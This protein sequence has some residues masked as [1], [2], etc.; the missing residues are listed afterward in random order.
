MNLQIIGTRKCRET[1]KA[2]RFFSDR[3]IHYAFVDLAERPLSAGELRNIARVLG[4]SA[5]L[6]TGSREYRRRG[7]QYMVFDT[8]SELERH[9]ELIR[10]PIVRSGKEATVG[11]AEESWR[12]W[13][14]S[15]ASR[16]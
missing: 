5:L 6:N 16:E 3:G 15:E 8:L 9:P 4:E 1:R 7:M 11:I 13:I 10:T 14:A 12:R 2:Q